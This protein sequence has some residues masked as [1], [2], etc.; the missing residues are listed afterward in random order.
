MLAGFWQRKRDAQIPN[1]LETDNKS[2]EINSALAQLL[3]YSNAH[4]ADLKLCCRPLV[5]TIDPL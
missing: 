2:T 1:I 3:N 4:I 5:D